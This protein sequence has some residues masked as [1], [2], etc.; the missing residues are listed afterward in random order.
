MCSLRSSSTLLVLV[1]LAACNSANGDRQPLPTEA[2]R[3]TVSPGVS[4]G[5]W[6]GD[7]IVLEVTPNG[8]TVELDCAHG[9]VEGPIALGGDGRFEANGTYVQERG[10]PVREGEEEAQ[11]ARYTG[12]VERGRMTLTIGLPDRKETLGPFELVH[13]RSARL[14]KCL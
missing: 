13:G 12:R 8:A 10:G 9:T 3:E 14:V 5:I 4:P 6:G 1:L 11:P 2:S 7:H